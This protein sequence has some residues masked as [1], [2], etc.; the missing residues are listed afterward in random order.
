MGEEG[1]GGKI[2]RWVGARRKRKKIAQFITIGKVHNYRRRQKPGGQER[3]SRNF[4]PHTK[5]VYDCSPYNVA[6]W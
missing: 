3:G 4:R 2:R 5:S 1:V 6:H